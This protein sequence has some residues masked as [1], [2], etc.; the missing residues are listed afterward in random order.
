MHALH[1]QKLSNHCKY[2]RTD[3]QREILFEKS[4]LLGLGRQIGPKNV[5]VFMVLL[6]KT[7]YPSWYCESVLY[8]FGCLIVVVFYK[9]L[10]ISGLKHKNPK[11]DISRKDPSISQIV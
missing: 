10:C 6:A 4:K 8:G 7:L 5:V 11:S 9:K 3:T 2:T 1:F